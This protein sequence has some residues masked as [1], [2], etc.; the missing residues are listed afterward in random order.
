MKRPL[1]ILS[2]VVLCIFALNGCSVILGGSDP[3][4]LYILTSQSCT[5][6]TDAVSKPYSLL[7]R[8]IQASKLFDSQKIVFSRDEQTRGYYQYAS[9]AES[10]AHQLTNILF[11][12]IEC[13]KIFEKVTRGFEPSS[14]DFSLSIE[15]LD[16]RHDAVQSPGE[17]VVSMRAEL[18][19]LRSRILLA[20]KIFEHRT[21]ASEFTAKGAVTGFNQDVQKIY[22][23]MVAWLRESATPFG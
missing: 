3:K 5:P 2:L 13:E 16:F 11:A 17:A 23:E 20:S 12:R 14:T 21:S 15:I 4:D 18:Y 8:N 19:D 22:D 9:W 10:P 6:A 1:V 7:V